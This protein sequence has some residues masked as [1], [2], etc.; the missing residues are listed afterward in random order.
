MNYQVV[1]MDRGHIPAIAALERACFSRPWSE[2]ALEEELYND[3]ACFL[4]AEGE[5]GSVL[6]YAGL[7]VILDEGYIDNV[8]VDPAYRRQGVADALLDVFCRFGA[9][10]LAFLTLE[11]RESN[12]PAIA[13]Y[14]K[15]GFY[16]VG[17]RKDYYDDPKEDAL[18]L[19]REW[20][21]P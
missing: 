6:G 7:H 20:D 13:L 17:R 1:P 19:T 8:A 16:T 14:E 15:H 21:R 10:K 18:L 12:A 5:D 2:G 11:V 4:V 3:T 9:E